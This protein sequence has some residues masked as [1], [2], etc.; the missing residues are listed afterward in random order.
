MAV[1]VPTLPLIAL[2]I[3]DEI[4]YSS[5]CTPTPEGCYV[6]NEGSA[7]IVLPYLFQWAFW[8]FIFFTGRAVVTAIK[9]KR[10]P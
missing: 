1:P 6:D 5:R 2:A 8:C 10:L 9:Q 7:V 4:T 3:Y